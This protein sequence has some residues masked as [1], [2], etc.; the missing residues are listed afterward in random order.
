MVVPLRET[1]CGLPVSGES[2]M[3][4]LAARLVPPVAPGLKITFTTQDPVFATRVKPL[5]QE[6]VPSE[7]SLA[8]VPLMEGVPETLTADEVGLLR[9]TGCAVLDVPTV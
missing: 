2:E 3:E 6:L 5:V 4:R 1:V 8:F 7:K 9:V